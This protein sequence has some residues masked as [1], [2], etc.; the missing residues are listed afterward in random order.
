MQVRQEHAPDDVWID[1]GT[2]QLLGHVTSGVD[3][4]SGSDHIATVEQYADGNWSSIIQNGTG[5]TV[6]VGQYSNGNTSSVNQGGSGNLAT[7]TQGTP[8][9]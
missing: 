5:N 8:G 4:Q 3:Q 6:I 1:P 7:V 2:Q 9:S